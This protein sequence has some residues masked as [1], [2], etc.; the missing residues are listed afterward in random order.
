MYAHEI[1]QTTLS[2]RTKRHTKRTN[3]H[4]IGLSLIKGMV[5][6][7]LNVVPLHVK[8]DKKE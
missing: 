7:S 8:N 2:F 3:A 1:I 5:R 4:S 6:K